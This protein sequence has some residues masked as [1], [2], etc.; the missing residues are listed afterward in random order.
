[1]NSRKTTIIVAVVTFLI[2]VGILIGVSIA[3][4]GKTQEPQ[5]SGTDAPTVTVPSSPASTNT[6]KNSVSGLP[7][8]QLAATAIDIEKTMRNWGT[9][10]MITAD[11]LAYKPSGDVLKTLQAPKVS[12]NPLK[13]KTSIS[14]DKTWGADA[15]SLA[16]Q[17]EDTQLLC[18]GMPTAGDWLAH[19]AWAY[20]SRWVG[21][22]KA[23]MNDDGTVRVTGTVRSVLLQD[24]DTFSVEDWY[25][26]T[27][28]WRDYEINDV[29]QFD[30]DG[31]VSKVVS[32]KPD[33]WWFNPYLHAW[34]NN[35]PQDIG[36]GTRTL[37]PVKGAPNMALTHVP[38]TVWLKGARSMGEDTTIDWRLWDT[39]KM[40][41]CLASCGGGPQGPTENTDGIRQ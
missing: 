1:M 4:R 14:F 18:A 27:P 21:E 19:D 40:G 5:A 6:G 11:S 23:V 24:G 15:P 9:D 7:A 26:L 13:D 30:K 38:G 39:S 3:H 33:Y 28:A 2:V 41:V 8:E 37:I 32:Y 22:P 31:K 10:S 12:G 35:M 17:N 34:N 25:T 16:C 29:V 20:G 36:S